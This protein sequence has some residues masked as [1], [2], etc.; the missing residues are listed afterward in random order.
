MKTLRYLLVAALG[1]FG[2]T[3]CLQDEKIVKLKPDGSGTIEETVTMSKETVAMMEGM[4]G[5]G[6]EA[7]KDAK[8]PYEPDEAKLKAA[9]EKMGT[10][11]TFVSAKPVDTEKGKGFVAVYAFKDINTVKLGQDPGEMMADAGPMKAE[12]KQ[13]QPVTFKFAKGTPAELKIYM[14]EPKGKDPKAPA[15]AEGKED[16]QQ[17]EMMKQFFKDMKMTMAVEVVGT[18]KETNAEYKN[19]SRVT[20]VEMDFNKLLAD[21]EKFKKLAKEN[22]QTLQESKA[23]LKGVEGIKMETTP[24]VKIKFQ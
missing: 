21:P 10:G 22:P 18:I 11:V 23:L 15:P 16:M 14:P 6:G 3:G 12:A 1:V 20:L 9:A 17:M 2:L 8:K 4:A 13:E 19:G 7:K 5:M 24:E